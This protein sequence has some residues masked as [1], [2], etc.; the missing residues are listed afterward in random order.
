M[1]P[2]KEETRVCGYIYIYIYI[3][4][5]SDLSNVLL[6]LSR[7]HLMSMNKTKSKKTS[8]LLNSLGVIES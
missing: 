4:I 2:G 3:Y 8:D 7:I 6:Y 1:S 5:C